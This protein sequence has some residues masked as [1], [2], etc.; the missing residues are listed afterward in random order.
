MIKTEFAKIKY[1]K[2]LEEIDKIGNS[3]LSGWLPNK[4]KDFIK[5]IKKK[6]IIVAKDNHKIIGYLSFRPDKE[7][8][9][10]WLEDTYMLKNWRKR[11]IAKLLIKKLV[12]Y[13]NKKFPKRKLV[14]LTSDRNLKIFNK[15]GFIK[16]MNF[17]EYKK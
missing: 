13:K 10:L 15:L 6:S 7:S 9:W 4:E 3:E 17:M 16:T 1:A 2:E 8:K 12:G 14:L 11:G 5:L